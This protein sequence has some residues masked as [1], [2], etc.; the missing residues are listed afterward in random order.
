VINAPRSSFNST[1]STARTSRW[2]A[3]NTNRT[4]GEASTRRMQETRDS[5][6]AK[7][8]GTKSVDWK[9][10]EHQAGLLTREHHH[11][12]PSALS[13]DRQQVTRS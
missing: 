4:E 2:S 10:A 3:R 12:E 9:R 13:S 1:P 11:H 6:R 8:G 7:S 5:T